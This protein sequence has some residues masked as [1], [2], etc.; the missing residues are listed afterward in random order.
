[1]KKNRK[2]LR[3]DV[4]RYVARALRRH[5][6]TV[7]NPIA[8]IVLG[9]HTLATLVPDGTTVTATMSASLLSPG[10]LGHVRV[11]CAG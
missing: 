6:G 7:A 10:L 2:T 8:K 5:P 4:T 1:M 11:R 9:R 3:I